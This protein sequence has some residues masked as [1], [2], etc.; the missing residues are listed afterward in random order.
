MQSDECLI[1][2]PQHSQL[3]VF[4]FK[5]VISLLIALFMGQS[6]FAQ[7]CVDAAKRLSPYK[8]MIMTVSGVKAKDVSGREALMY[9][10]GK[11][12]NFFYAHNGKRLGATWTIL[13]KD[14]KY[15]IKNGDVFAW[16]PAPA[17][18]ASAYPKDEQKRYGATVFRGPKCEP[19]GIDFTTS[20]KQIPI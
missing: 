5:S 8:G 4:M 15:Q 12:Y 7:A 13:P 17:S 18:V 20:P 1:G 6:A 2:I 11:K 14:S 10:A 9:D 3:E 16:I 19:M